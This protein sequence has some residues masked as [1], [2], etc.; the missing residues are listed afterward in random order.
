LRAKEKVFMR[1]LRI[2][3]LAF[4]AIATASETSNVY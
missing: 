2:L 3:I 4:F 1:M